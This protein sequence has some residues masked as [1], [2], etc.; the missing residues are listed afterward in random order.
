MPIIKYDSKLNYFVHIPKCGG[1]SV[2]DYL[3]QI[4]GLQMAFLDREYLG[5]DKP[6]CNS[7]PQH[8]V[9]DQLDCL[10][11]KLFFDGA[12]AVVRHP[13]S[14]FLSAFHHNKYLLKKNAIPEAQS[15]D[16][17]IKEMLEPN[18][19]REGWFDNHFFPQTGFIPNG[20]SY[21]F[22]RLED[23]L[24]DVKSH[25][26]NQIIGRS[27]A[28]EMPHSNK[29][30]EVTGEMP[31]TTELSHWAMEALMRLYAVDFLIFKYPMDQEV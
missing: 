14:R 6:W 31:R 27:L 16:S 20:I 30:A 12:F 11:P 26:D 17:F 4:V 7:S 24:E 13:F 21:Q 3:N 5:R 19:L 22:F 23:G 18:Y 15:V 10:F 25:I 9:A 2:E 29:A 8:V 28:L 1:S